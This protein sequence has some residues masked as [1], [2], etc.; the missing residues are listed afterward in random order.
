MEYLAQEEWKE[1]KGAQTYSDVGVGDR[2]Q[3]DSVEEWPKSKDEKSEDSWVHKN[4]GR[5]EFQAAVTNVKYDSN[6]KL[7]TDRT[8]HFNLGTRRPLVIRAIGN[9]LEAGGH[10]L[11]MEAIE[12]TTSRVI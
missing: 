5:R 3:K 2:P 4:Q 7:C 10:G 9:G 12:K 6:I 11:G 8:S 1:P